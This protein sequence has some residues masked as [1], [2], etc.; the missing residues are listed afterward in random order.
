MDLSIV[1]DDIQ[2]QSQEQIA[3]NASFAPRALFSLNEQLVI[4]LLPWSSNEEKVMGRKLGQEE[5]PQ[6]LLV[7]DSYVRTGNIRNMS[8]VHDNWDTEA[9][10]TY[11]ENL[12]QNALV[13]HL[14]D[15][16]NLKRERFSVSLYNR[17]SDSID[18]KTLDTGDCGAFRGEIKNTIV[19]GFIDGLIKANLYEDYIKFGP[20]ATEAK[21][22]EFLHS[23]LEKYPGIKE[24]YEESS[25]GIL[26]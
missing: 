9:P 7:L 2:K 5:I 18:F 10:S 1:F 26:G 19:L 4:A 17:T 13:M 14:V 15:F 6:V 23:T 24:Y 20:D 21:A 3:K 8:Y 25:R 22:K 12:R 11:P 16:K